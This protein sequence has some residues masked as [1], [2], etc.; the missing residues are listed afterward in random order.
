MR[1]LILIAFVLVI[2]RPS[3]GQ[4]KDP[5]VDKLRL[6][7][8]LIST[9]YV[10]SVDNHKMAEEA[11]MGMLERLDP[12]SVYIP[13]EEVQAMNEPLDGNF[14]G[15]GIEFMILKDTLTVVSTISGGPS[16][17]VG[18]MAGD[19]IVSIDGEKVAG[20][21]LSNSDVFDLLRG[22]KGTEVRMTVLR[23][24]KK[25]DFVVERDEIPIFS[26]EAS[27]LMT[28]KTG[29]IKISR[30]A[31][32]THQEFTE[33]LL[34]LKD[35]NI[36]NLVLDLR[37]N[38]GGYLKAALDIADEFIGGQRM[39][40]YTDGLAI[41][42]SEYDSGPGD[43]WEEGKLAILIDEGSASASEI[44]AGAVQDWDR[45]LIIG[46]RSF[47]KGLVQR[48]F[49]L[50]DGSE[51]RLT[52]AKYYT[53]SGRCI[54]KPYEDGL[55]EY[56]REIYE[57]FQH[58]E[59]MHSDSVH[60]PDSLV[61]STLV[62]ERKVFGGGGI[63]PDVFVP[64]DTGNYTDYYRDLVASGSVNRLVMDKLDEYRDQWNAEYL[65]FSEFYE[66]FEI[67][68]EFISELVERGDSTG[69]AY[70]EKQLEI[71]LDWL[72]LQMKALIARNLWSTSEYYQT[73]NP[74]IPLFQKVKR[75]INND[76]LYSEVFENGN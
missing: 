47:G 12:H 11:I 60:L 21:G 15:V 69:I 75:V 25:L 16:E 35:Q 14:E 10:D 28:P 58:G 7:W 13:E 71:S 45:G 72:K 64:L 70:K 68:E 50:P 23:N 52:I 5:E 37:G 67:P 32:S 20:I 65:A 40:L 29:Y 66:Q 74:A 24:R 2:A 56:H 43:L 54:Q 38:G 63:V 18:L 57:R 41:P 59:M 22:P 48:P 27:Y 36:E 44:V 46:R 1:F 3:I 26:L 4:T 42:R 6:A 55:K 49:S 34:Q 73:L 9:F 62:K 30:F 19:R 17:K 39:L 61:F 8:Q 53:P 33:A 31:Q 51:I 76:D